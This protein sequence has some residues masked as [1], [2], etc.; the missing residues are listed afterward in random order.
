MLK[1]SATAFGGWLVEGFEVFRDIVLGFWVWFAGIYL[2]L[3]CLNGFSV[4][5]EEVIGFSVSKGFVF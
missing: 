3:F 1:A 4:F 2:N 5:S